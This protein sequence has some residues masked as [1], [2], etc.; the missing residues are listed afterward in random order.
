MSCK[1]HKMLLL[2]SAISI[3]CIFN[4]PQIYLHFCQCIFLQAHHLKLSFHIQEQ[5]HLRFSKNATCK[6]F[7]GLKDCN[8]VA[9][10]VIISLILTILGQCSLLGTL[11]EKQGNRFACKM[12]EKHLLLDY[13]FCKVEGSWLTI[14]LKCHSSTGIF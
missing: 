10:V 2:P 4:K 13:I 8:L 1:I 7:R 6:Q 9:W 3:K 5:Q 11:L 12:R 14:L